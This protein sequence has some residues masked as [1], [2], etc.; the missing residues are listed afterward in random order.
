MWIQGASGAVAHN[1]NG[2]RESS[3][4]REAASNVQLAR[5]LANPNMTDTGWHDAKVQ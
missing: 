1:L 4:E 5:S 2:V 3:V